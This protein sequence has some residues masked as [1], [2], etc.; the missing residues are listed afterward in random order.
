MF[1]YL[2]KHLAGTSTFSAITIRSVFALLTSFLITLLATPYIINKMKKRKLSQPI[3]ED[4]PKSHIINKQGTPSMGGLAVNI[5]VILSSMFWSNLNP[6]ILSLFMLYLPMSI[7]GL[8]DDLRKY[9]EEN[10]NGI[11]AKTKL[12]AQF[13]VSGAFTAFILHYDLLSTTLY[14]PVLNTEL[15]LG[16]LYIPFIILVITGTS[17]AVNLTDG[18]DGLAMGTSSIVIL[19]YGALAYLSGHAIFSAY[20]K[21]PHLIYASELL[22]PSAAILGASMGFLWYNSYPAQIFMGDTGSLA[23]GSAIGGIA[24]LI[25]Q[26]ILLVIMGGIFVLEAISVILQVSSFKLR[27]KKIFKMAPIHHHFELKG[28]HEAKVVFRFWLIT[29]ILTL[30]GF[31][32]IGLNILLGK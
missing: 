27:K 4:G 13:I 29:L 21:I 24:V 6:A 18:L 32:I 14:V 11:N 1:Y 19:S 2:I 5:A 23:L 3:R 16:I 17:N 20:L 28:W 15:N 26:E 22:V 8:F 12:I 7:I 30:F 10:S 9:H 25:K 31:I